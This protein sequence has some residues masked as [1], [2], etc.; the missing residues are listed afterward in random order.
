VPHGVA[1][2]VQRLHQAGAGGRRCR[3]S[4]KPH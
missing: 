4:W 1:A 2:G 3:Q